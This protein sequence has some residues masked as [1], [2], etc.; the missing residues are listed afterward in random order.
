[1]TKKCYDCYWREIDD[2]GPEGYAMCIMAVIVAAMMGFFVGWS[3]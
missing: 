1:M 3:I 2:W